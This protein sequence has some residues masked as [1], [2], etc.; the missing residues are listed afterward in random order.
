MADD[1][2]LPMDKGEWEECRIIEDRDSEKE[3]DD[4][5]FRHGD[6]GVEACRHGMD[7]IPPVY[8][9]YVIMGDVPYRVEGSYSSF[10]EAVGALVHASK[11]KKIEGGSWKGDSDDEK[12]GKDDDDD[13]EDLGPFDGGADV[14][15]VEHVNFDDIAKSS[16]TDMI[17]RNRESRK[18]PKKVDLGH[19]GPVI[20]GSEMLTARFPGRTVHIGDGKDAT[21]VPKDLKVHG[22][23]PGSS[24]HRV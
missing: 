5:F 17:S 23:A 24:H 6:F 19:D 8:E 13:D 16:I 2:D 20:A 18:A 4:Q 3:H 7:D 10:E 21:G 11:A 9:T 14:V 15:Y 22:D 12:D 1:M